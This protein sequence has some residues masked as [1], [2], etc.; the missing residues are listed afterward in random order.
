MGGGGFPSEKTSSSTFL[1]FLHI[2]IIGIVLSKVSHVF[3]YTARFA[4][5]K[6]YTVHAQ[7]CQNRACA[8]AVAE[9]ACVCVCVREKRRGWRDEWNS[10]ADL[11]TLKLSGRVVSHNLTDNNMLRGA[12]NTAR[13]CIAILQHT[14]PPPPP[15]PPPHLSSGG[16]GVELNRTYLSSYFRKILLILH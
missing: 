5:S 9:G 2:S 1:Y 10:S 12:H 7:G 4:D 8:V 16:G 14:R 3:F 15:P 13:A 6:H 11:N